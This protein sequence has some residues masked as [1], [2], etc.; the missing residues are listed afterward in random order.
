MNISHRFNNNI[1]IVEPIG[2]IFLAESP[3]FLKYMESVLAS[4]SVQGMVIDLKQVETIDSTGIGAILSIRKQLATLEAQCVLCTLQPRVYEVFVFT[5][6][7]DCVTAYDT[8]D[9]AL[10]SFAQTAPS[11]TVPSD[12]ESVIDAWPTLSVTVRRDLLAIIQAGGDR[13]AKSQ[14]KAFLLSAVAGFLM[15]LMGV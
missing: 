7:L 14:M 11:E 3:E 10:G 1:C 13:S 6:L 12:L 8:V 15:L 2:N 4:T 9:E 5:K